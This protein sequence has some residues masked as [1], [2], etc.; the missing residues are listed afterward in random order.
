MN[1]DWQTLTENKQ[2]QQSVTLA[3]PLRTIEGAALG[4]PGAG[5]PPSAFSCFIAFAL[6]SVMFK[7]TATHLN[8][9]LP[10]C[11][12]SRPIST[13]ILTQR[14]ISSVPPW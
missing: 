13:R 11:C 4:S 8:S 14:Y 5:P 10:R 2:M 7:S 9:L 1:N 3:L 12:Q 6:V